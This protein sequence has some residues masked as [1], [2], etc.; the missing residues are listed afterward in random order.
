MIRSDKILLRVA[1]RRELGVEQKALLKAEISELINRY[2]VHY[3]V[4]QPGFWTDLEAMQRF[5]AVLKSPQFIEVA[6]IKTPANF[7]SSE[8][9]LFIYKNLGPVSTGPIDLK[10]DLPIIN[11]TIGGSIG[12]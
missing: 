5:E 7:N 4:M 6:R 10:I 8:K 12:K 2:G 9:E 11:R 1:V 3:V